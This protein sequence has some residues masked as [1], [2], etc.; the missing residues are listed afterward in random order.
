MTPVTTTH[1]YPAS[2]ETIEAPGIRCIFKITGNDSEGE[3]GVYEI[4]MQPHTQ[5]AALHYH[6]IITETFIV[7]SGT[8]TVQLQDNVMQLSKGDIA[9]VP[10][11]TSHGFYNASDE[12][13]TLLLIF[14]P[15]MEREGFF[16]ALYAMIADNTINGVALAALNNRYDT[17]PS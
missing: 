2:F 3:I 13:V 8:L 6:R 5:G 14:T 11:N 12:V 15:A 16:R 10:V 9:Y 7:T 1:K 17:Y 4:T